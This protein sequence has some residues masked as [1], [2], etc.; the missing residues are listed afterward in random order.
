MS[1]HVDYLRRRAIEIRLET[2]LRD[3]NR[4]DDLAH[5]MERLEAIVGKLKKTADDVPVVPHSDTRLWYIHPKT[6]EIY[7]RT[8]EADL[9][10]TRCHRDRKG[11]VVWVSVEESY[12]TREAAEAAKRERDERTH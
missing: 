9:D 7:E 3:S 2:G 4:Y 8:Y 11:G 5:Y 6:G 10:D 1:E 12:S